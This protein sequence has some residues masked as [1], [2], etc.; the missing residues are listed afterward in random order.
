MSRGAKGEGSVYEYRDGYRAYV[1]VKG[2]RKYFYFP[3]VNKSTAAAMLRTR[4]NQRDDGTLPR[5]KEVTLGAWMRHWV[6][7]ADLTP[8]TRYNYERN[9]ERYVTPMLGHIKL[10]DLEPEDLED[11]YG[12]MSAGALSR[13]GRDAKGKITRK[14][15]SGNHVRNV[16][17]NIRAALNVAVKRR[18]VARNVALAVVLARTEK[19]QMQTLSRED[20]RRVLEAAMQVPDAARWYLDLVY[21]MRPAEVLGLEA[22]HA[23][24]ASGV[25]QVRQ[26]LMR[27]PGK[28]M[29]LLPYTK[30]SA[31]RR[32][33]PAPPAL[34][35]LIDRARQHQMENRIAFGEK[36][37][38][39]EYEGRPTSLLFTLDDGRPIDSTVDRRAWIALL[40]AVGLPAERRYIGRHT[41]ASVMIDMG[42][43][44][45]VVAGILGHKKTS[46]TYDTYVH[47]MLD[48]KKRATDQLAAAYGI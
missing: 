29:L 34:F 27:V 5:G 45:A 7:A 4:L 44:V 42:M 11:L 41:A 19:P 46:F 37:V 22:V 38:E 9:I 20:A 10:G 17:A 6:G 12:A 25:I 47:P 31:G 40:A 8:K 26:Q 39:W 30:T 14:P 21:G 24:R 18:R 36:Y 43:D 28:G 35:D 2:K 48:A 15:L 3:D 33:I 1:T 16:H 23:D 32:D 13:P